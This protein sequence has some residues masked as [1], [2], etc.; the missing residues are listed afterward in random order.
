MCSSVTHSAERH[1]DV[2]VVIINTLKILGSSR[3]H[4][5]RF[6]QVVRKFPICCGKPK[7]DK[8]ILSTRTN[9]GTLKQVTRSSYKTIT[10]PFFYNILI[11]SSHLILLSQ[12]LPSPRVYPIKILYAFILPVRSAISVA[13]TILLYL[14]YLMIF[15]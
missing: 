10:P 7:G 12:M 11:L 2:T 1:N 15:G 4:R 9:D 13:H 8:I 6:A 14:D 3:K 5:T